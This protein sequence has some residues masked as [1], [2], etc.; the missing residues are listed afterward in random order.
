MSTIGTIHTLPMP[1][2]NY[3]TAYDE[4]RN[5]RTVSVSELP[6]NDPD[7][8]DDYAYHVKFFSSGAMTMEYDPGDD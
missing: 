4:Y 1:F 7:P 8:G 2:S 5:V 3:F 6:D